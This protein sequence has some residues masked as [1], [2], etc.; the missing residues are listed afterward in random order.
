MRTL[1]VCLANSKK[2]RGRCIAGIELIREIDGTF[3]PVKEHGKTKWLRPVSN[4]EHGEVDTNIVKHIKLHDLIE[5]DILEYCP[6]G[7]QSENVLFDPN[8]LKVVGNLSPNP[9]IL[10]KLTDNP[11]TLLGNKGKAVPEEK[12]TY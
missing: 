11:D 8:S 6:K 5:M 10:D 9:S 1:F 4:A 3:S 2:Y 12:Y 7:Y